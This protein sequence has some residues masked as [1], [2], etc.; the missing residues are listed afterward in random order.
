MSGCAREYFLRTQ[1][2]ACIGETR[3]DVVMGN[4]GT[5]PQ[6]IRLA[7]FI[8]HQADHEFDRKARPA[9]DRFAGQHFGNERN[10]G[11]LGLI[12]GTPRSSKVR[13]PESDIQRDAE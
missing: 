10:A 11:M 7:P 1:H 2:I 12:D 6:N 4:A 9:D 13:L 5:V 8:S 3:D